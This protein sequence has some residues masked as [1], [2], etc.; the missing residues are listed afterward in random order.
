MPLSVSTAVC[1]SAACFL[2]PPSRRCIRSISRNSGRWIR[3]QWG[4][5]AEKPAPNRF[6]SVGGARFDITPRMTGAFGRPD[7]FANPR[8]LKLLGPQLGCEIHLSNFTVVASHPGSPLQHIHRDLGHLFPE[9][10][11]GPTFAGLCGQRGGAADRHRPQDRP[12]RG[13]AWFTP[14]AECL[15]TVREHDDVRIAA[16]RLHVAGLSHGACGHAQCERGIT[17]DRLHGLC[18]PVILRQREPCQPY[19]AGHADRAL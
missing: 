11:V 18:A 14:L 15:G 10:A 17:A 12:D 6:L 1:C 4:P 3:P 16:R 2:P 19:P 7:V 8:L 9:G 13:L 5:G